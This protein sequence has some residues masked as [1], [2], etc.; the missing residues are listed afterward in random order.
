MAIFHTP[1]FDSH[2]GG[3]RRNIAIRFSTEKLEWCGYRTMKQE[4]K[5]IWQKAPGGRNLYH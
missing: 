5:V 3:L 1:A 4:V 2:V